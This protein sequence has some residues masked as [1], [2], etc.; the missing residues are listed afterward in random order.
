MKKRIKVP[1]A[2]LIGGLAAHSYAQDN[3]AHT[4]AGMVFINPAANFIYYGNNRA[5]ND[6]DLDNKYGWQLGAE[7]FLTDRISLE[8][9]YSEDEPDIKSR[10]ARQF[11]D[12]KDRRWHLDSLYYFPSA[13]KFVPYVVGGVGE[14]RLQYKVDPTYVATASFGNHHDRETE[15]H[16]GGGVRYFITDHLSLRADLRAVHSIDENATDAVAALG[17]SYNFGGS[18]P[19]AKVIPVAYEAPV[20]D[21]APPAPEPAP[22]AVYEKIKLS[23]ETLFDFNKASVHP[24]AKHELDEL[25]TKLTHYPQQIQTIKVFGHTDR[26]GSDA[27]NQKL[28]NERAMA[29]KDYLV[30]N[31]VDPTMIQAEGKGSSEPETKP[32]ECKGTKRSKALIACLQPDRRVEIHISI[33][34][35]VNPK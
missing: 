11:I 30:A 12:V 3:Y 14:G 33:K 1:L 10:A 16:L 2:I 27:Y 6:Y 26:I 19:V 5:T 17:I 35:Q 8:A 4:S 24:G 9:S 15:L 25:T 7:Y 13:G 22:A 31:G 20:V 34:H 18:K 32:D 28:S 23:S 29:V 21:Q